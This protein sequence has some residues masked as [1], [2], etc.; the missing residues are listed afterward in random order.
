MAQRLDPEPPEQIPGLP[1]FEQLS[2][3][4]MAAMGLDQG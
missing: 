4:M 2:A 3:E 1:P